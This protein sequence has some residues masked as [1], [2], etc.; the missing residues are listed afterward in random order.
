MDCDFAMLTIG[1]KPEVKLAQEAGLEIG[2]RSG[3]KVNEYLQ[4]GDPDIYAIG[5]AVE[6][7]DFVLGDCTLIPLAGP[8]NK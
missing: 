4:T 2:T 1:V 6:V 7:Q 5:D 8:A 3:I